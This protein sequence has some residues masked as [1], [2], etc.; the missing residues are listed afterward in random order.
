ML[1]ATKKFWSIATRILSIISLTLNQLKLLENNGLNT[2]LVWGVVLWSFFDLVGSKPHPSSLIFRV[3][4]TK[5]TS[6][7][8]QKNKYPNTA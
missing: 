1:D 7:Y 5:Y 8:M 4:I 2:L 3:N 6:K